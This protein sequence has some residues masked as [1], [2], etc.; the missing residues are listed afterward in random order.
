MKLEDKESLNYKI[1]Q[2]VWQAVQRVIVQEKLESKEKLKFEDVVLEHPEDFAHGDYSTNIALKV[3]SPKF[4]VKFDLANE[5]ANAIRE[6]GLPDFIAKIEVA[7]PG[8]INLWLQNE[9][10][11][12]Q[13]LEVLKK[14]EKYGSSKLG[15][16]KTMVIDYSSPNIAKPFGVGH[17]RSTIIGQAIYNLYKFLGWRTI[18]D[19]HLGDWGTQF[20]KLIVAIRR[21]AKK[22]VS[23]LTVED[24]EELYV[25]FHQQASKKLQLEDEARQWFKKLEEGDREARKIWKTCVEVSLKEFERVYKLL[26]IKIDYALGES[27]YED[28]MPEVLKIAARKKIAKKSQGA[29]V[30]DLSEAGLPPAMLLKSDGATT[31]L[32]RDLATIWYRKRRWQPDLY[33]YEVGADQKLHFQQLFLAAEK[34][35]LGKLSQFV[36][37]PHGLIRFEEG[38]MSTLSLIHI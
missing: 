13:L 35:G 15:K 25:K 14:R 1:R 22:P 37:V 6:Q 11:I 21:W 3:P 4:Q 30:I 9:Y 28:K 23:Q 12:N 33:I 31:Y 5:I 2:L 10:L 32:L 18:G 27:F 34:L 17:L 24:L 26:G 19:N 16:G 38:K 36:H 7:P 8:F 20:G 29:L